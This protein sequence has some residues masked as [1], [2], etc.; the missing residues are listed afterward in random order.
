MIRSGEQRLNASRQTV[1]NLPIELRDRAEYLR[2][3]EEEV[4]IEQIGKENRR[5]AAW[6]KV[7]STSTR[8]S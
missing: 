4:Q 8:H 7:Q 1:A 2:Q 5:L 6:S 3:R